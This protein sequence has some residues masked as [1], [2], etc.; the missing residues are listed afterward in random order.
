MPSWKLKNFEKSA[1]E[2]QT[3]RTRTNTELR[4]IWIHILKLCG[5]KLSPY[6][7]AKLLNVKEILSSIRRLNLRVFI[8][9]INILCYHKILVF[10]ACD[11]TMKKMAKPLPLFV[12]LMWLFQPIFPFGTLEE[13]LSWNWKPGLEGTI[14][15]LNCRIRMFFT[16]ILHTLFI[17]LRYMS[18]NLFVGQPSSAPP[19]SVFAVKNNI[20]P[21]TSWRMVHSMPYPLL[22]HINRAGMDNKKKWELRP[23]SWCHCIQ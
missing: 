1:W 14:E 13:L 4:L 7:A 22:W 21:M 9:I 8:L 18:N 19:S 23:L 5:F 20:S 10:S 17:K 12:G 3:D 2:D 16:G 15:V 6:I 11:W